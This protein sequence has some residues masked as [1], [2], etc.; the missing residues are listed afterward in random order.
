MRARVLLF[1]IAVIV[2]G[3]LPRA[4]NR[5]AIIAYVFAE[6]DLIDPS[7]DRRR[8]ADAHQ[9]RVREH[10]GRPGRGRLRARRRELQAAGRPPARASAAQDPGLGR[11]LDLVGRVLGRGP[12]DRE[13]A[14]IRRE[15]GRVRA[16]GTIST[17]ST[18]TGSI[19][20]LRGLDNPHRPEDKQNFT[21]LMAELRAALDA[22]GT[23]DSTEPTS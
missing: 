15:R 22:R 2:A 16:C 11:R 7:G 23:R 19:P 4:T 18:S 14:P 17:A 3:A 1:A 12:D 20:G 8:Q 13:P 6:N 21:A 9:L 5:A 10:Q